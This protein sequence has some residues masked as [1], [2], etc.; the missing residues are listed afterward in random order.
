MRTEGGDGGIGN[1]NNNNKGSSSGG[2]N[3]SGVALSSSSL[4]AYSKL[5]THGSG[6][7]DS[8]HPLHDMEDDDKVERIHR[9]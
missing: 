5:H 7:G 8:D 4:E 2:K 6:L 1:A 3:S 9:L